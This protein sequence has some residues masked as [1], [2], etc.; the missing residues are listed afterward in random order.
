MRRILVFISIFICGLLL[1]ATVEA[2][3]NIPSKVDDKYSRILVT[4]KVVEALG[5][6]GNPKAHD[7]LV[8]ALKSK[9]FFIRAHAVQALGIMRDKESIPLLR[10]MLNDKNYLVRISVIGALI[11]LDQKDMEE[12]LLVSLKDKDPK[13][14]VS[15]IE[16]AERLGNKFLS[17]ITEMLSKEKEY[18]VRVKAIEK[19][20]KRRFSPALPYI[21]KALDD[22]NAQV[23]RAA[24]H[25]I[26]EMGDR[27]SIPQILQ[28][29]SDEN[30]SVRAVAKVVL[31]KFGDRSEIEIFWKEMEEKDPLLVVTSYMAL[32]YLKEMAILPHLLEEIVTQKNSTIIRIEA[33]K[34]LMVLK[35]YFSELVSKALIKS[36]VKY[37]VLLVENMQ[38]HYKVNGK[39]LIL[40]LMEALRNEKNPLYRDSPLVLKELR[41]RTA[42]PALREA[43][44]QDNNPDQVATIAYVLGELR[45]KDAFNY[46]IEVFKKYGI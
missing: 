26:G 9:E 32:A 23:R 36:R 24:C 10:E 6:L 4:S 43:L 41:D 35:P 17:A 18:F 14:R 8:E 42:L 12:L 1:I 29:L 3:E 11:N 45:D 46:L 34:A 21:R 30:I 5:K 13:V 31:A 27:E 22:E 25:A 20:G 39:D 2:Q 40:I 16:Q 33:A 38:A 44:L 15:T 37:N 7:I 19:L 28:R